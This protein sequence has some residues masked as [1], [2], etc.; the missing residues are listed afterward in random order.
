MLTEFR[1]WDNEANRMIDMKEL[2]DYTLIEILEAYPNTLMQFA[3]L[4]DIDDHMIFEGDL[5]TDGNGIMS[6]VCLENSM[7]I[8]GTSDYDDHWKLMYDFFDH[9]TDNG[10]E[11][12]IVGNIHYNKEMYNG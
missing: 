1:A 3:G 2:Q 8:L 10:V 7:F 12:K 9:N 6:K 4:Y 5:V 11:L